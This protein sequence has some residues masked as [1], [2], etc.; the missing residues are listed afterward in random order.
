VAQPDF[1]WRFPYVIEK[2]PEDHPLGRTLMR[3]AAE[4]RLVG[5]QGPGQKVFALFDSGSDY[6]LAAPWMA[7]EV[8]ISIQDGIEGRVQVGGKRRTIRLFDTTVR[9][10]APGHLAGSAPCGEGES[11]SWTAE[12]GFFTAWEAPPWSLILGQIGFFDHFTVVMNRHAQ[13]VA[14]EPLEH[15]DQVY[16]T[17]LPPAPTLPAP[18]RP[19]M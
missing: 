5:P 4:A 7:L 6:T 18:S 17:D 15:F 12:V 2:N 8:G 14:V 19:E 16:G 10:C 13:A 9:L 11:L 3:P 1:P